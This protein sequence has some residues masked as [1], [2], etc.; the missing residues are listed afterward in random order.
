M[1]VGKLPSW[2]SVIVGNGD[3]FPGQRRVGIGCGD[4]TRFGECFQTVEIIVSFGNERAV[5]IGLLEF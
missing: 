1:V 2:S 4:A 3:E 5:G